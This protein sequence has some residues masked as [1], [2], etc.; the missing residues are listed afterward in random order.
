MI[1]VQTPSDPLFC[2]SQEKGRSQQN[3]YHV[4]SLCVHVGYVS[5]LLP[6]EVLRFSFLVQSRQGNTNK[7]RTK[8]FEELSLPHCTSKKCAMESLDGH[9]HGQDISGFELVVGTF[10]KRIRQQNHWD[11][12]FHKH[13]QQLDAFCRYTS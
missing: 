11:G 9:G 1:D 12:K 5:V 8:L 10:L 13:F 4:R 2:V 7:Q 6:A 3:F